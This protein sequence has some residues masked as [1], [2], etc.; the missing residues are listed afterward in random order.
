MV[1]NN[2]TT[3]R[4]FST[5]VDFIDQQ[6]RTFGQSLETAHWKVVDNSE[7]E[8]S[9]KITFSYL[10]PDQTLEVSKPMC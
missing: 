4:T 8:T 9:A 7:D 3:D 5:S 2:E 1:G 10:S 6:L